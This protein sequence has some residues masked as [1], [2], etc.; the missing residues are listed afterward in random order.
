MK[1]THGVQCGFLYFLVACF[2]HLSPFPFGYFIYTYILPLTFFGAE[3]CNFHVNYGETVAGWIGFCIIA[4]IFQSVIAIKCFRLSVVRMF[5]TMWYT[6][7]SCT[8]MYMTTVIF[9]NRPA[10]EANYAI[11][12]ASWISSR[13]EGEKRA[14]RA[15]WKW[16]TGDDKLAIF[17]IRYLSAWKSPPNMVILKEWYI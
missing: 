4:H 15:K 13:G 12:G 17:I 5:S 2:L 8:L 11:S 9:Q 10:V 7:F 1:W 14:E 3:S 16:E 6:L